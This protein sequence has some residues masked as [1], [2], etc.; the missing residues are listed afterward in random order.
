MVR[1]CD[2]R[3]FVQMRALCTVSGAGSVLVPPDTTKGFLPMFANFSS[4][5]ETASLFAAAFASAM[6]LISAA[7]SVSIA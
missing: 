3:H 2:L 6:L 5:R 7:T 1:G 4:A